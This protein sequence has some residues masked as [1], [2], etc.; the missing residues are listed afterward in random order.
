MAVDAPNEAQDGHDMGQD[1]QD[2]AQEGPDEA[3]DVQYE[4]FLAGPL[5]PYF[6][7]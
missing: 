4:A 1:V 5:C 2:E 6:G 7:S 3:Q